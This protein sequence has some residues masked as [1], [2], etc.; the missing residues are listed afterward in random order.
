VYTFQ[1]SPDI[2]TLDI[3]KD[4]LFFLSTLLVSALLNVTSIYRQALLQHQLIESDTSPFWALE[5]L[6]V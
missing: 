4:Y 6:I 2:H 5:R 3:Q 1:S